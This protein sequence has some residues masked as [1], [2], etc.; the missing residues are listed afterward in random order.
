MGQSVDLN[1]QLLIL[2][3]QLLVVRLQAVGVLEL[4]LPE[5]PLGLAVLGLAFAG[6]LVDSGFTA[7]FGT[8]RHVDGA[9]QRAVG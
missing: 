6:G 7:R 9:A 3:T 4:S 1:Q 2:G 5:V 8:G